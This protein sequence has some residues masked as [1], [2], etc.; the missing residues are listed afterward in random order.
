MRSRSRS[1][2]EI[3]VHDRKL[4][5]RGVSLVRG[6]K[7]EV[8]MTCA[9]S[10]EDAHDTA[11]WPCMLSSF[12]THSP[13]ACFRASHSATRS[14]GSADSRREYARTPLSGR[15]LPLVEKCGVGWISGEGSGCTWEKIGKRAEQRECP[16]RDARRLPIC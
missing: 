8:N 1:R 11:V 7:F 12:Q 5:A 16:G 14:G 13:L 6:L 15:G 9:T 4:G 10:A 2:F 3:F